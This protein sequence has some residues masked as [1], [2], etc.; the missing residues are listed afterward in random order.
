MPTVTVFLADGPHPNPS[1]DARARGL[2]LGIR[3]RDASSKP[4]CRAAALT[5]GSRSAPTL[6]CH[7]ELVEGRND[8][9]PTHLS[10]RGA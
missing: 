4:V 9:R 1:P 2:R 6:A 8:V 7:P 3:T 10:G 5:R